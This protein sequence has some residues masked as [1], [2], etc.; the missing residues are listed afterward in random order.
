MG[1]KRD[2]DGKPIR[3][4]QGKLVREQVDAYTGPKRPL[5]YLGPAFR[6]NAITVTSK[7]PPFRTTFTN[8]ILAAQWLANVLNE[9]GVI[10]K[11]ELIDKISNPDDVHRKYLAGDVLPLLHDLFARPGSFRVALYELEDKELE[12]LMLEHADRS[13]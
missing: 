6:T 7:R 8:G 11:N 1:A 9:D 10:E 12:E 13:R 2:A 5:A 4:A 3:D